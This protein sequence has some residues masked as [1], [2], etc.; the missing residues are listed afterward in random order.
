MSSDGDPGAGF[1]G[2]LRGR[3]RPLRLLGQGAFG[4]V[5]LA[6][7]REL[8]RT[9]AVKV[10]ALRAGA[11]AE[12]RFQREARVLAGLEHENLVRLFE[13][14]QS[15]EGRYMVLEHVEGVALDRPPPDLDLA[16][17]A[18][19][20]AAGLDALHAQDLLHR[21]V[22]PANLMRTPRGRVVLLDLGLAADPGATA[23][24]RT[25]T[26]VGSPAY[27]SPET[28]TA[29]P[30]GPPA[31]YWSLGVTL[32]VL[33]EGGRKPWEWETLHGFAA[34][35]RPLPPPPFEALAPKDPLAAVIRGLLV[36]D[37]ALRLVGRA[38]LEAALRGGA[39]PP[40]AP[41]PLGGPTRRRSARPLLLA[42]AAGALVAGLLHRARG[43][44]PLGP[45]DPTGPSPP[46]AASAPRARV[47]LDPTLPRRIREEL[48]AAA[49]R[50]LDPDGSVRDAEGARRGPG[51][52]ELLGDDPWQ[53]RH[54]LPHLS[55]L[56]EFRAWLEAG[57]APED[58]PEALR[59]D[60]ARTDDWFR[61]QDQPRPF[62]P[63]LQARPAPAPVPVPVSLSK[64][65]ATLPLPPALGGWGGAML[66][67]KV[68]LE[69][70]RAAR[71]AEWEGLAETGQPSGRLRG[72]VARIPY[73]F[74]IQ[75]F[76]T[77]V[78]ALAMARDRRRALE[79]WLGEGGELYRRL[80]WEATR[81]LEEA[82]PERDR[83]FLIAH[84]CLFQEELFLSTA[85]G[86]FPVA[87]LAGRRVP[88]PVGAMLFATL[89]RRLN[90][91]YYRLE[92]KLPPEHPERGPCL[93]SVLA[94][95]LP[96]EAA[97][98]VRFF[99]AASDLG[100]HHVEAGQPR[101][102]LVSLRRVLPDLARAPAFLR[103]RIRSQV[104]RLC[105]E[106]A[107][108][109]TPEEV[110]ALRRVL[111]EPEVLRLEGDLRDETGEML[112]R[113]VA[114]S[115]LPAPAPPAPLTEDYP[116]RVRQEL[117]NAQGLFLTPDGRLVEGG[118]ALPPRS[119]ELLSPD[120][121]AWEETQRHLPVLGEWSA[122]LA[123]GGRPESL[124]EATRAGLRE[125]DR[126]YLEQGLPPTFAPFLETHPAREAVAPSAPLRAWAQVVGASPGPA[127]GWLGA[128]Y[129]SLA[130]AEVAQD[131]MRQ[132]MTE[133]LRQQRALDGFPAALLE[134]PAHLH[135]WDLV[136][137]FSNGGPVPR[138]RAPLDQWIRPVSLAFRSAMVA[139]G[140]TLEE[141]PET[142]GLAALLTGR[143]AFE[144]RAVLDGH[145][146]Q[147][148]AAQL[149]GGTPGGPLGAYARA[150]YEDRR[151][152]SMMRHSARLPVPRAQ[153]EALWLEALAPEA[154]E[155]TVP[156]ALWVGALSGYVLSRTRVAEV[157][158]MAA[159]LRPHLPAL[160]RTP[161]R[162]TLDFL[163][164]LI[165]TWVTRSREPIPADVLGPLA[166]WLR[167][168]LDRTSTPARG[169][170]IE[171]ALTALES[172][173]PAR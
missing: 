58:L 129:Q 12:T 7:D 97:G 22:K 109:A 23:L 79:G 36:L 151:A 70:F 45:A 138:Y 146:S 148:S 102:A 87:W 44:R 168:H 140:R 104:L 120:P 78:P 73:Q 160:R 17:V 136:R 74:L 60:L 50:I 14:G 2:P 158:T 153:L 13:Q 20:V 43:S 123:A 80:A 25:G 61:D 32:F 169:L 66:A 77:G 19:Q 170:E 75:K 34:G 71:V 5:Y 81:A 40:A 162:P 155:Q 29:R 127:T 144:L 95:G 31:D 21:D 88:G 84:E 41:H 100:E 114:R 143:M 124:P 132:A 16:E 108:T 111:V 149:L 76:R 48:S 113:L 85:A 147:L 9:V 63:F 159:F 18:L 96:A 24:T 165:T 101:E 152:L 126:W 164:E 82:G 30:Q 142:A 98:R 89:Y 67:T 11:D 110:A 130:R 134:V 173:L 65:D 118:P 35:T 49:T 72:E 125:A 141:E 3:Y 122:W 10:L 106:G 1:P 137:F 59:Q 26:S 69:E 86:S 121:L 91:Q 27:M 64:L 4:R 161:W 53:W 37:P 135:S 39:P 166:T 172:R 15:P 156:A 112:A 28:L 94:A 6:E 128:L 52:R 157:E 171:D 38:A 54:T 117:T 116:R 68:A 62:R 145:V 92:G 8:E 56:Q 99:M 46:P 83:T 90:R 119:R 51:V 154:P 131:R 47:P 105:L 33:A 163:G 55:A 167:A 115:Q 133:S 139:L 57:G 93:R 103:L 150:L 42:L 107:G